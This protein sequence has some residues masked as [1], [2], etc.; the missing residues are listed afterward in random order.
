MNINLCFLSLNFPLILWSLF[1]FFC[2][3][4]CLIKCFFL[5]NSAFINYK[6]NHSS[7]NWIFKFSN[8]FSYPL[9]ISFFSILIF[10]FQ[11]II[12]IFD[13]IKTA[14]LI[15]MIPNVNFH[16]DD[17]NCNSYY[18][19][20]QWFIFDSMQYNW[21]NCFDFSIFSTILPCLW[22]DN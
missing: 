18:Y 9:P 19:W 4:D 6:R 16:I 13:K 7:F 15:I 8:D 17:Y 11:M 20:V 21:F 5:S 10:L 1:L 22:Y 2:W 12:I 14:S 3:N